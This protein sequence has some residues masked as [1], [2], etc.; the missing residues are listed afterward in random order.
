MLLLMLSLMTTFPHQNMSCHMRYQ[1]KFQ[2]S[3]WSGTTFSYLNGHVQPQKRPTLRRKGQN[4]IAFHMETNIDHIH[5]HFRPGPNGRFGQFN[6]F[7][8]ILP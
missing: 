6:P 1:K 8:T 3:R 5:G 2:P 7:L 4:Y